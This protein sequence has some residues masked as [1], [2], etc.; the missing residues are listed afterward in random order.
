MLFRSGGWLAWEGGGGGGHP[1][2]DGD[3]FAE[4]RGVV[5]GV[6][7]VAARGEP[8][9]PVG[10][11]VGGEVEGLVPAVQVELDGSFVAFVGDSEQGLVGG[12]SFGAG[13]IV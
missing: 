8:S 5:A 3:V 10:L 2:G 12:V 9:G 4:E 13:E 7:G 6:G 11:F 1:G